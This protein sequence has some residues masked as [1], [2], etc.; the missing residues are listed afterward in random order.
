MIFCGFVVD[1]NDD[2][3]SDKTI[4][5]SFI[6]STGVFEILSTI[7]ILLLIRDKKINSSYGSSLIPANSQ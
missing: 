3:D 5:I 1:N 2:N 6:V 4:L 7:L